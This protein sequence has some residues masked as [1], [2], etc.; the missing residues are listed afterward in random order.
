[1]DKRKGSGTGIALIFAL[2][3]CLHPLLFS[4]QVP[5]LP[6]KQETLLRRIHQEVAAMG[7]PPMDVVHVRDFFF[8]LDGFGS[9]KEEHIVIL[10]EALP[11]GLHRM[12][13]QVTFFEKVG[14]NILV[15][16]ALETKSL[17]CLLGGEAVVLENLSFSR[18][19]IG[20]F[21]PVILDGIRAEKR[22]LR[23]PSEAYLD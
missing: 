23:S 5:R 18:E 16:H 1:M 2:V 7:Q 14:R 4:D 17:V 9:N 8:E 20:R 10:D 13:L 12:I 19:E 21:L 15:K 22:A 6:K 11:N 3:F